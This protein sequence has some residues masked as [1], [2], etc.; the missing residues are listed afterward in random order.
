M[1]NHR[2]HFT[3]NDH[4]KI[5]LDDIPPHTPPS[6][7]NGHVSDS[8]VRYRGQM[9]MNSTVSSLRDVPSVSSKSNR[10][11]TGSIMD[12]NQ[13]GFTGNHNYFR[14]LFYHLSHY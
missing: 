7:Q 2:A 12:K 9:S 13:N 14:K 4:I 8:N 3:I 6:V 10:T 1:G 5:C 11:Q